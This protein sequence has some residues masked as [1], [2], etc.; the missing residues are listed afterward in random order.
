MY[1]FSLL[2]TLFKSGLL[3]TNAVAILHRERFLRKCEQLLICRGA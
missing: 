3:A 2:W 1:G